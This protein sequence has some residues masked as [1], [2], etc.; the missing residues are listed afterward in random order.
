VTVR[1]IAP[2]LGFIAAIAASLIWPREKEEEE[3]EEKM[4]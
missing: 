3:L 1:L 4:S 2:P